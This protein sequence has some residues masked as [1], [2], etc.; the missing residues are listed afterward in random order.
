[1][2]TSSRVGMKMVVVVL[3]SFLYGISLVLFYIG[4]HLRISRFASRSIRDGLW[5]H[6]VVISTVAIFLTSTGHWLLT[7]IGFFHAVLESQADGVADAYHSCNSCLTQNVGNALVLVTLWIGEAVIIHRLWVIWNRELRVIALP[8]LSLLG[9]IACGS[10]GL[11]AIFHHDTYTFNEKTMTANWIL[12]LI[13]NVYCTAFIAWRVLGA[14]QEAHETEARPLMS[15]LAVLVESAAILAAWTVFYAVTYETESE[16]Q[17]VAINLTAQVTGL[18]NMFIHIRLGMA[19]TMRPR[20]GTQSSDANGVVMTSH[21]SLFGVNFP[22]TTNSEY[23][24]SD[25]QCPA[26]DTGKELEPSG[27][28]G[29]CATTDG[30]RHALAPCARRPLMNIVGAANRC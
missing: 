12:R 24:E 4:F 23:H 20:T 28:F 5:W 7:I 19:H 15:V 30:R 25:C 3:E 29:E 1:M 8:V 14:R 9:L 10:T 13:T 26:T 22:T 21:A 11:F 18:A 17:V 2:Y 16:L 27:H 6:P